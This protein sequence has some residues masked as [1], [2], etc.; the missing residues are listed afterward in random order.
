MA[1]ICDFFDADG[2]TDQ[3]RANE[4]FNEWT[5]GN[6][7]ATQQEVNDAY[8]AWFE[9]NV[10]EPCVSSPGGGGEPEPEPN[11]SAIVVNI[12]S[13]TSPSPNTIVVDYT[14][15]NNVTSGSGETLSPTI[16]V[17]V[18]GSSVDSRSVTV[19]AGGSQP[20]S[21]EINNV[22]SGPSQVCVEP[23]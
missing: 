9:G 6:I 13:I 14:V 17:A 12:D 5:E 8:N 21:V 23:A 4:M 3:Q 16:G 11:T 20:E 19:S 1:S 10:Y 18:D 2:T 7:D 22:S 15:S